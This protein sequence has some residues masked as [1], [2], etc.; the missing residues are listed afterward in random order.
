MT[1]VC[2]LTRSL[3]RAW[4]HKMWNLIKSSLSD[5]LEQMLLCRKPGNTHFRFQAAMATATTDEHSFRKRVPLSLTLAATAASLKQIYSNCPLIN[6]CA[7]TRDH[8]PFSFI[9]AH[10]THRNFWKFIAFTLCEVMRWLKPLLC[11][12]SLIQPSKLGFI[13]ST[14][15]QDDY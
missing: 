6:W 12:T 9:V 11:A 2:A 8:L 14:T 5:R 13:W 7:I 4:K 15:K 3:A 1:C 10:N